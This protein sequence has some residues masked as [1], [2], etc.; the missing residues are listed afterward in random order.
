MD[1]PLGRGL[2][3]LA[4]RQRSVVIIGAGAAA[5]QLAQ[6]LQAR[7]D[8][9][10]RLLGHFDDREEVAEALKEFHR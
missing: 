6:A 7:A 1:A 9:S 10:S 3:R 2:R 4:Q 8:L 5:A